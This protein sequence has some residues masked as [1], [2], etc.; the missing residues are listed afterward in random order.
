[1]VF[2]DGQWVMPSAEKVFNALQDHGAA[3]MFS[4]CFKLGLAEPVRLYDALIQGLPGSVFM[5]VA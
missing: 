1:M 4:F 2:Q 5:A 3:Q